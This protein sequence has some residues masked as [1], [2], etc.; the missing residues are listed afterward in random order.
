M[1]R[2]GA[3]DKLK[4]GRAT[5]MFHLPRALQL[6][7]QHQRNDDT[8]QNDLFGGGQVIAKDESVIEQKDEWDMDTR[9]AGERETLGL[10]L[11]GHPVDQYRHEIISIVG[12][13]LRDRLAQPIIETGKSY[14]DRDANMVKVGGLLMHMRLRNSASGRMAFLTLD[15]NTARVDVAVFTD[16]YST[17]KNL[18]VKD[19]ILIIEG[20][21]SIDEYNGKPR[22]RAKEI[23]G[24]EEARIEMGKRLT[25]YVDGQSHLNGLVNELQTTLSPFR[26]GSCKVFITYQNDAAE[27]R[28]QLSDEWRVVPEKE[29]LRRLNRLNG[30]TAAK[31]GY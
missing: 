23:V 2:C 31:V 8:G 10:Y 3:L 12:K 27:G 4:Y 19:R 11:T 30:V 24:L 14:R 15:D 9:L 1:I 13:N 18:L 6:A 22:I 28:Y 5:L 29:L 21:M 20:S 25:I 26:Q 7:E 16:A 17:Y